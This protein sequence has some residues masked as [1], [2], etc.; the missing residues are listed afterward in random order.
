MTLLLTAFGSGRPAAVVAPAP[1][2]AGRLVPVGP[3]RPQVIAQVGSLLIS[4]PVP[5]SRVTAIGYHGADPGA[6]A[7]VPRGT[8]ANQGL[9]RRLLHRL[10]GGGSRGGLRYYQIAG[11]QGP[12]TGEVDI[13]APAGTDVYSPVDGIVIGVSPYVID[14]RSYGSR[15]DIQP[16]GAPSMVVSLTHLRVDPSLAVGSSISAST[17]KIGTVL[18][19]SSV[20]SQALAHYTQDAGN[21]AAL[22]VH[23]A[24]VTN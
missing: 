5:Q 16:A 12:A 20:E 10:G 8:Q 18:D 24:A 22:Q 3:P 2:P 23:P 4:M 19:F 15:I 9:L 21:H 1:A 11:G 7:L 14:H 13:G 6:L 17:S